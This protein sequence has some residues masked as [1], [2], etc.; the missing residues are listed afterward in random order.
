MVVHEP[1]SGTV[2]FLFTD[3]EG[4][5]RLTQQLG[6]AWPP[7]LE[8]HR[9]IARASW[10]EH[11][12]IEISTEGD[13]FFVVFRSP[14]DA[15]AAAVQ[16]QHGL[17]DEQ[18]PDGGEIR[19]RMGLHTGEGQ[20]SGGSYVG[21]D[22]HRAARIAGA[23]HGG[24]VLASATTVSL[25]DGSGSWPAGV[26]AVDLGEHRL[27]DLSLPERIFGLAISGLRTDF[28]PLKTLNAVVNNL[29]SQLTTFLGRGE[30]L[31]QVQQLLARTR[32]L[33]LLGPGGT[34]KTR[35]ALQAA[36]AVAHRYPDGV[37]LV[38]LAAVTE[39]A[40]VLPTLTQALGLAQPGA[41][42]SNR[43]ADYL[44]T[45]RVLLVLDNFEQVVDAG[46][47]VADLLAAAPHVSVLVTSRIAL[48]V[49]GEREFHVPPLDLPDPRHLPSL[50][51]LVGYDAVAL[52]V[53]RAQG[54]R[55]E[56]EL[57]PGN[58]AA[59]AEICARLD[60]LPLA[61]ELAA[62]RIRL[63]SP[64]AIRQKLGDRLT[65]L[66]G[67]ALDLP[68]RQRTL[69]GAIAWSFDLLDEDDRRFFAR[70]AVFAGGAELAAVEKVVCD[71]DMPGGAL[72]GV[73]SML[74]KSL[75][76]FQA[77]GSDE[78]RYGMLETIREFAYQ[79]LVERGEG[80]LVGER[81][82]NW[83]ASLVEQMARTVHGPERRAVLDRFEVEHDNIR[84][85]L[86]WVLATGRSA[87]A[88]RVFAGTWR[89]WQA[90][91]FLAEARRYAERVM[92]LPVDTQ[93]HE[94]RRA[95][96]EAAAGIAYW[97]GD[98]AASLVWY[99]EALELAR[100]TGDDAVIANALYNLTFPV[101]Q[102]AGGL[103]QAVEASEEA[104]AL[105]R[106]VGD[107]DGVGRALWG[108]ATTYYFNGRVD[109]GL[110]RAREALAV[111]DGSGDLFMTAWSQYMV[112]VMT[113]DRPAAQ[114]HLVAAHR[115]FAQADDTSG[116]ALVLDALGTLAW[117]E[118]DV[119]RAMRLA[120]FVGHMES[121]SGSG[122][123]KLNR[124]LAGFHPETLAEDPALAAAYEEGRS[125][126]MEEAT[127][128]AL[129]DELR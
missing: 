92:A 126:T 66:S 81:H 124:D 4:S 38:P 32:L 36:A 74:D 17:A 28:P 97:Q 108:L 45:R 49:Y 82:A 34:G 83:V 103:P 30:E 100:E 68:E 7:L 104:I 47:A 89:Y 24:Q 52:F 29:P 42:S 21:I 64:D 8:R 87:L 12:G 35:L 75:I 22:V 1:P 48:Q 9:E 80:D 102:T 62:A 65:F 111:L 10:A 44:A 98:N 76:R 72:D 41:D 77:D 78:P 85:A 46:P 99:T 90:R 128:L 71:P 50:D 88:S 2:T 94:N 55:P 117:R 53:E 127:A 105:Y 56:F 15:V 61:I 118:G 6:A 25:L 60:G 59:V 112:G 129:P 67:G 37:H 95:A 114:R 73:E 14:R 51:V 113:R 23:G 18:W 79:R 115:L 109:E 125:L 120:G 116:H 57:T 121:T 16:A 86:G 27:K 107:H 39:A 122:L 20:L 84:A 43:L 110:V 11:A 96:A 19:V 31:A 123:A 54:V 101:G 58:A 106:R 5:T 70:F 13:S 119:A 91:G 26:A 69:R 40:L 3:I 93:A 33:T 63:L